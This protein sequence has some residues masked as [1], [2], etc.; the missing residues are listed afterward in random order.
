MTDCGPLHFVIAVA[1]HRIPPKFGPSFLATHNFI[2][3][4]RMRLDPNM[5][6]ACFLS[7]TNVLCI[8]HV[9]RGFLE[10]N[11]YIQYLYIPQVLEN[12]CVT[13]C[14]TRKKEKEFD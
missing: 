2:A 4:P 5:R 6:S 11:K 3:H 13:L 1:I 10:V 14:R 9:V 7:L 12:A 8:P